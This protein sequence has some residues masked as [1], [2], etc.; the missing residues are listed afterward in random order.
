[1]HALVCFFANGGEAVFNAILLL[2]FW[3]S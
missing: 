1:M 3:C 2:V